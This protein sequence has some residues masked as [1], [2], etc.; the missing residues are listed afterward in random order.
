MILLVSAVEMLGLENHLDV[1][2]ENRQGLPEALAVPQIHLG[3]WAM[4][5]GDL[6]QTMIYQ[7]V[8]SLIA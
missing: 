5:S 2:H 3:E 8:D 4:R 1:Y 7:Q 6:S